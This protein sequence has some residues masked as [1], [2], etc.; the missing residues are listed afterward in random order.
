MLPLVLTGI[1]H[2]GSRLARGPLAEWFWADTRQQLPGLSLALMA[3]LL[4]LAANV[5]VSTMVGSFRLTFS[6][7]LDQRLASEALRNRA[8]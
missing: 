2:L 1:L 5:G 4:A 8:H 7:W 3:L 6:G